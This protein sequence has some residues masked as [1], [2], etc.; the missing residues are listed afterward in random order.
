LRRQNQET[1]FLPA[2]FADRRS[3]VSKHLSL[4]SMSAAFTQRTRLLVSITGIVLLLAVAAGGWMYYKLRASLPQLDGT[5]TVTGL[6][7][8]VAITRDALGIPTIRGANREDVARA[9]GFLHA[10][11]RFFQ[12]DLLRRRAA[13]ELAELFGKRALPLDRATRPHRFRPLAQKVLAGL[14][15]EDRALLN[16]YTAGVNAGVAALGEKPFEYVLIRATP[17]EWKAEDSVLIVYA[18]TLDLQ[19]ATNNYEL[20]LAT[21]RDKLGSEAVSF[22]APLLTPNDAALDGSAAP[23]PAIPGPQ[24]INLR[25]STPP[26]EEPSKGAA[27]Q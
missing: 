13:G 23:L 9:F 5:R 16:A 27:Q 3:H 19:D 22:F 11:D 1:Y 6:S 18:M 12:M 21:L 4:I 15:A 10:Q 17:V 26:A 8:P 14:P 2:I 20:S 25:Q 7:A 24:L